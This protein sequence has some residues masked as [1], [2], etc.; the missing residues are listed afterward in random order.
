MAQ[1][2]ELWLRIRGLL[3]Q[4]PVEL[5][6]K[7]KNYEGQCAIYLTFFEVDIVKNNSCVA[8][9][10]YMSISDTCIMNEYHFVPQ[11]IF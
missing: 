9:A 10:N 6:E 8:S 11:A 5:Q 3:D 1:P 2:D 4:T 7:S